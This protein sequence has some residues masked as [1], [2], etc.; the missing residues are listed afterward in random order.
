MSAPY[1]GSQRP[2]YGEAL[3]DE[4]CR[5][6]MLCV[7][8]QLRLRLDLGLGLDF[9]L[10]LRS[11]GVLPTLRDEGLDENRPLLSGSLLLLPRVG[12]LLGTLM[13]DHLDGFV[14]FCEIS[15]GCRMSALLS[16]ALFGRRTSS[17]PRSRRRRSRSALA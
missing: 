12:D 11:D 9:R 16:I 7:C 10:G 5:F 17:I 2:P 3:R 1:A 15:A 4:P 8:G 6:R 13:V 14:D